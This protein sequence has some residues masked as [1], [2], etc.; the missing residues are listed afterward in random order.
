MWDRRQGQT[1]PSGS[2]LSWKGARSPTSLC[3]KV[4]PVTVTLT[5]VHWPGPRGSPTTG[6]R[7]PLCPYQRARGAEG[8]SVIL[9]PQRWHVARALACF[10][11]PLTMVVS[12]AP[13]QRCLSLVTTTSGRGW[14]PQ[15]FSEV[16]RERMSPV[17]VIC[18]P[19]QQRVGF[20]EMFPHVESSI[21]K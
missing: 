5:K 3:C 1:G 14:S 10:D 20:I 15:D 19:R 18:S 12:R 13:H 9:C 6:E 21:T 4:F 8:S 16:R 7:R 17:Q 11:N 2:A